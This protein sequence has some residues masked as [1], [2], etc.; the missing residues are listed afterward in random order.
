MAYALFC[1]KQVTFQDGTVWD[2]P[3]YNEWIETYKGK[4][5]DISTLQNYYPYVHPVSR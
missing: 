4:A 5:A 1:V 3:G 2:N